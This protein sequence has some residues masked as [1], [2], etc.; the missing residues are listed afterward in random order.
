[1]VKLKESDLRTNIPKILFLPAS[2]KILLVYKK[3]ESISGLAR[4]RNITF[5]Q[6][7]MA[8]KRLAEK[9]IV[10]LSE[11]NHRTKKVTLTDKGMKIKESL[12]EIFIILKSDCS[13][14]DYKNS[15]E[16]S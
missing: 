14:L 2:V 8:I 5:P 12:E 7:S 11:Y 1:M 4:R 13:S 9:K 6:T 10:L 15:Y 16:T 3:P